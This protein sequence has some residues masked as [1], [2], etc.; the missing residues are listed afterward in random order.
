MAHTLYYWNV[1]QAAEAQIQELQ[2]ETQAEEAEVRRLKA[3]LRDLQ[4]QLHNIPVSQ[5]LI[6]LGRIKG[7]TLYFTVIPSY[8]LTNVL[9]L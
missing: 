3:E 4:N 9:W 7:T 6:V 8:L 5:V 2:A 1:L